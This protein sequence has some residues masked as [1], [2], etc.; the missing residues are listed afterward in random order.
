MQWLPHLLAL[1]HF[2]AVQFNVLLFLFLFDFAS[3]VRMEVVGQQP[4]DT[5]PICYRANK[6]GY[7]N[8]HVLGL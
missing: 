8:M 1:F 2:S 5:L 7:L 3:V 6:H 4:M